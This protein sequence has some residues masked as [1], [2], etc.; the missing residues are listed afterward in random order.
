MV[1]HHIFVHT[2]GTYK[3]NEFYP[4]LP[5]TP[6]TLSHNPKLS[7]TFG[8]FQPH[9]KIDVEYRVYCFQ[10][11]FPSTL[12]LADMDTFTLA[13][14]L[15]ILK[16]RVSCKNRTLRAALIAQLPKPAITQCRGE[17][18]MKRGDGPVIGPPPANLY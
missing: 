9:S 18:I 8:F 6:I 5:S 15:D 13:K 7:P 3:S 10:Y 16:S 11:P 4:T 17:N 2:F 1:S 14:S 12:G